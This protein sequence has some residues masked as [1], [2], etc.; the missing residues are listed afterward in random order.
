MGLFATCAQA[1]L[2]VQE[3]MKVKAS[4]CSKCYVN[5]TSKVQIILMVDMLTLETHY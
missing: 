5:A 2:A 4:T 3:Q 1:P